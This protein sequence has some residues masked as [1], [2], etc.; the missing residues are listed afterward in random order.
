MKKKTVGLLLLIVVL[1]ATCLC[2]VSCNKSTDEIYDFAR[3][4]E[5]ANSLQADVTMKVPETNVK[6]EMQIKVDDNKMWTSSVMGSGETYK[7][8]VGD[9]V[10]TYTNSDGVWT[11]TIDEEADT[12]D[13]NIEDLFNGD[14][15]EYDRKNKVFKMK[16][17][18]EIDLGDVIFKSISLE[19]DGKTCTIRGKMVSQG[20][21]MRITMK[22]KKIN[23]TTVTL[24][25]VA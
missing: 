12:D 15:Y 23:K 11:K 21:T 18:E 8:R 3:I 20:V 4:L 24:P 19:I 10:Y 13:A 2:F 16:E 22:I 7:E 5:N 6:L 25:T 17:D 9:V 1:T 14:K